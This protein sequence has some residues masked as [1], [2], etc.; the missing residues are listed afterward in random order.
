[1]TFE[2][3]S[4]RGDRLLAN[5]FQES[6]V[7]EGRTSPQ[8]ASEA[9]L[10]PPP[11]LF[12]TTL[13]G[14]DGGDEDGVGGRVGEGGVDLCRGVEVCVRECERVCVRVCERVCERV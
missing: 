11:G 12:E 13:D 8:N 7:V 1:M 9:P 4:L 6:G 5:S 2:T 3:M 10:R 14:G